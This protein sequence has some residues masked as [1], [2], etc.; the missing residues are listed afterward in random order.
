[1]RLFVPFALGYFLSYF[2]RT[3]NAVIAPQLTAEFALMLRRSVY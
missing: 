2:F 1:M 3:I